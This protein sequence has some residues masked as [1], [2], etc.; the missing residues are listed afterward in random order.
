MRDPATI[1]LLPD[2]QRLHLNDGPI[3]LIIGADGA[4]K[5]IRRA[6]GAAA[7]RFVRILDELCAELPLLRTRLTRN[8]ELPAGA[9]ARRMTDAVSPYRDRCFI[10]P[11]AAVAGAVA[12]AV[13][14]AMTKAAQLQRFYV[15]NGGDIAL[16][17]VSGQ[18]YTNAPK[19]LLCSLLWKF[20]LPCPFGV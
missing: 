14:G 13:L 2:G 5:E 7:R 8:S 16:H 15:N 17:L 20:L 10:T 1:R 4:A 6:Y 9:I 18:S 12:E 19:L 11:M 3:D